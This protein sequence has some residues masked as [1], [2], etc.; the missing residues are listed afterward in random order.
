[1]TEH[2]K[3]LDLEY[4]LPQKISDRLNF[5]NFRIFELSVGNLNLNSF[6][7]RALKIMSNDT[8][9]ESVSWDLNIE[10]TLFKSCVGVWV[11]EQF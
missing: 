6:E 10:N 4:S 7:C 3:L 2:F 1:M 5:G 11:G 8:E 9:L